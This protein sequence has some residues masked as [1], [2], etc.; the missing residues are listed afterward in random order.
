M[1]RIYAMRPY[2]SPL[3]PCEPGVTSSVNST[4]GLMIKRWKSVS[5]LFS[6]RSTEKSQSH[7]A[8]SDQNVCFHA[9]VYKLTGLGRNPK[10]LIS[11]RCVG[12]EILTCKTSPSV[13]DDPSLSQQHTSPLASNAKKLQ[14]LEVS[15]A[16]SWCS[17]A[18]LRSCS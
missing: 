17:M 9:V 2:N 7:R 16:V 11:W 1:G 5:S 18:R 10:K 13:V 6:R 4:K 8:R 12:K 3:I 15:F 14:Q